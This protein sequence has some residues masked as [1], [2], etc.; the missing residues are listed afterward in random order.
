M[1]LSDVDIEKA[2]K[3]GSIVLEPFNKKNLQPASYDI[4]LGNRFLIS[5]SHRHGF[6]DP[7]KKIFPEMREVIL[8]DGEQFILHPG[9][10]VLGF[11]HDYF[12][13]D[14]Y[15]IHLNGKSSLARIGLIVHNTAGLINPGHFLNVVF[16]LYN[17]NTIP[18]ILRPKMPIAQLTFSELSS[19]PRTNYEKVGRYGKGKDN[20]K[21]GIPP[22]K[23]AK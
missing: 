14:K 18:I 7:E 15:L 19:S 20:W 6:I 9:I 16:E 1:Y 5:E 21:G 3:E 23:R 12:G 22:K 10:V 8:K 2:V 17:T 13:S 4:L 11:S